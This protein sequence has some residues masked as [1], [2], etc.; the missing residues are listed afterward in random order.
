ME[1]RSTPAGGFSFPSWRCSKN[2]QKGKTASPLADFVEQNTGAIKDEYQKDESYPECAPRLEKKGRRLLSFRVILKTG[3]RERRQS[4]RPYTSARP[5]LFH[6][7]HWINTESTP[8]TAPC[9]PASF[10]M[11]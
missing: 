7:A 3:C 10:I 2:E 11:K 1:R 6:N 8:Y 5:P 9:S 4:V